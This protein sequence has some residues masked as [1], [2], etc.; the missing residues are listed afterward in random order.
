MKTGTIIFDFTTIKEEKPMLSNEIRELENQNAALRKAL[1]DLSKKIEQNEVLRPK[2]C[3]YCKNYIQH[4]IKGA[5][6]VQSEYTPIYDGH[7]TSGMP[8]RKG[9]RK[10]TKPDETCPYFELG[11]VDTKYL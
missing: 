8:I 9:G 5:R 3:Q 10:K 2:S 11:T 6:G 4:Y 1:F 7:C